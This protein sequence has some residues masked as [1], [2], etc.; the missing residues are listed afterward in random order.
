LVQ[1]K[2]NNEWVTAYFDADYNVSDTKDTSNYPVVFSFTDPDSPKFK[3]AEAEKIRQDKLEES[4]EEA[5]EFF[6][7]EFNTNRELRRR[8]I[9]EGP[10]PVYLGEHASSGVIMNSRVHS[11]NAKGLLSQVTGEI[12]LTFAVPPVIAGVSENTA[13]IGNRRVRKGSVFATINGENIEII[14][15]FIPK[16]T[17]D[18]LDAIMNHEIKGKTKEDVIKQAEKIKKYLSNFVYTKKN[19]R[20]FFLNS[21]NK[22]ELRVFDKNN[23]KNYNVYKSLSQYNEQN[24]TPLYLNISKALMND[25]VSYEVVNNVLKPTVLKQEDY[26]SYILTNSKV[27]GDYEMTDGK[28]TPVYVSPYITFEVPF[29]TEKAKAPKKKATAQA[30]PKAGKKTTTQ[31]QPVT[32]SGKEVEDARQKLKEIWNSI[33]NGPGRSAL[34][35]GWAESFGYIGEALSVGGDKYQAHGMG[36]SSFPAALK[37]LFEL[38]DKG[39]DTTRGG[40][41]LYTAPLVLSEENKAAASALG[42]AGGTAYTDGSFVLIAKKG[43]IGIK[44]INDV[45]GILVNSGL[46]DINAEILTELRKAFPNLVIESYKNTKEL[47]QQLNEKAEE[48]ASSEELVPA[49][50]QATLQKMQE[51]QKLVDRSKLTDKHYV[52]NGKT[53]RRTS[54]VIPDD[55]TG[56]STKYFASRNAG[57][58]SDKIIKAGLLGLDKTQ[59]KNQEL[60]FETSSVSKKT[61]KN[62]TKKG[63]ISEYTDNKTFDELYE[64]GQELAKEFA[65]KGETIAATDLV[66]WNEEYDT[67][68]EIDLLTVDTFGNYKIYDLKTSNAANKFRDASKL[69][70]Y[71]NQ[72]SIY[73]TL[74]SKQY[75][76]KVSNLELIPFVIGYLK[77]G[78]VV[79]V[80]NIKNVKLKYNKDVI[81]FMAVSDKEHNNAGLNDA[82]DP[83]ADKAFRTK[84]END[85][86]LGDLVEK[87]NSEEL[88][89]LKGVTG[90]AGLAVLFKAANSEYW[91]DF[92]I[93]GVNLYGNPKK[94]TG[95]HESFHVFSQMFLTKE[96]KDKLYQEVRDRVPELKDAAPIDVEEYLAE[97]FRK[98]MESGG[99]LVLDKTPVKKNFFQKIFEF[100]RAL[101][102]GRVSVDKVYEDLRMGNFFA[103]KPSVSNV[104][105]GKLASRK[106]IEGVKINALIKYS[107]AA[108]C[109]IGAI[110][111]KPLEKY[112]DRKLSSMY[113]ISD[114]LKFPAVAKIINEELYNYFEA[115]RD[116]SYGKEALELDAIL[117]NWS[118]FL[119]FSNSYSKNNY[120]SLEA[121]EKEKNEENVN[122][123]NT[124][125]DTVYDK[126]TNEESSYFMGKEATKQMIAQ[127]PACRWNGKSWEVIVSENGLMQPANTTILWNS[128]VSEMK[129]ELNH[130]KFFAKLSPTITDPETGKK[131]A[132]PEYKRIIRK[133]PELGYIME[134]LMPSESSTYK[135]HIDMRQAFFESF[136][137]PEAVVRKVTKNENNQFYNREL[138]RNNRSS[139]LQRFGVNFQ[140]F[141]DND[142]FFIKGYVVKKDRQNILGD[143]YATDMFPKLNM[144]RIKGDSNGSV[145]GKLDFLKLLG[146]DFPEVLLKEDEIRYQFD[147][148]TPILQTLAVSLK[149]RIEGGDIISDPIVALRNESFMRS[150]TEDEEGND[151]VEQI[152]IPSEKNN[153]EQLIEFIS[154]YS[155]VDSSFSALM[156]DGKTKYSIQQYNRIT[157]T[158]YGL[159]K[160]DSY[161]ELM[162]LYDEVGLDYRFLNV[163]SIANSRGSLFMELMFGKKTNDGLTKHERRR[164]LKTNQ[165]IEIILDDYTGFRSFTNIG[166]EE[167]PQIVINE[168]Y[169]TT[170]MNIRQ[171][172]VMDI[173]S[174]LTDGIINMIQPA[175][176][177]TMYSMRLSSYSETA[178]LPT[179][180]YISIDSIVDNTNPYRIPKFEE[181]YKNYLEA[182]LYKVTNPKYKKD[183]KLNKETGAMETYLDDFTYF[184]FLSP[185]LKKL[186]KEESEKLLRNSTEGIDTISFMPVIEK[187]FERIS[188]EVVAN[189]KKTKQEMVDLLGLLE[190]KNEDLSSS[191]TTKEGKIVNSDSGDL[192][193][194]FV[195]NHYIISMEEMKLFQADPKFYKEMFK[196][197]GQNISTGSIPQPSSEMINFLYKSEQDGMTLSSA[198]GKPKSVNDLYKVNF[199]VSKD[200]IE[201]DFPATKINKKGNLDFT[202]GKLNN[203]P[204]IVG[205]ALYSLGLTMKKLIGEEYDPF[206]QG[207]IQKVTNEFL[208]KDGKAAGYAKIT[209]TDGGGYCTLDFYRRILLAVNNWSDDQEA[210]YRAVVAE[211]KLLADKKVGTLSAAEKQQLQNVI[212]Y[213]KKKGAK[214]VFNILKVQTN[215]IIVDENG[216]EKPI[217][218]KFSLAPI[219]PSQVRTKKLGSLHEEML[220]KG[221]DYIPF[222]S[223]SKAFTDAQN[224]MDALTSTKPFGG[225]KEASTVI[226]LTDMKEQLL[227]SGKY[228]NDTSLGV[229]VVQ[230]AFSNILNEG[231]PIDFEGSAEEFRNAP[232][233]QLSTLGKY[234]RDY[235]T[236]FDNIRN[237]NRQKLYQELGIKVNRNG[238]LAIENA[239]LLVEKLQA[240]AE[241]R[242]ANSN[243]LDYISYNPETKDF[244][245]PLDFALNVDEIKK[246]VNGLID[247][248]LRKMRFYGSMSTQLSDYGQSEKNHSFRNPTQE[249][250]LEYGTNGLPFY[251]LKKD[252]DG[253]IITSKMG[254]KITMTGSY[255]NLYNLPEV[256]KLVNEGMEP[257]NALNKLLRTKEFREKHEEKLSIVGYRTPTQAPNSM[258]TLIIHEFLPELMGNTIIL[259]A[260]ITTKSGADYDIDKMSL[261]FKHLNKDGEVIKE[262]GLKETMAKESE[263]KLAFAELKDFK[264]ELALARRDFEYNE[265]EAKILE[266]KIAEKERNLEA[267]EKSKD[268][269]EELVENASEEE[270]EDI[271]ELIANE[272]DIIQ[273][274]RDSLE[275]YLTAIFGI[276][277]EKKELLDQINKIT[278]RIQELKNELSPLYQNQNK[279][280]G[281]LIN[282]FSSPEMFYHLT[283]PSS[284]DKIEALASKIAEKTGNKMKTYTGSEITKYISSLRKFAE[285]NGGK[286]PLGN[287]SLANKFFQNVVASDLKL[288]SVFKRYVDK[289]TKEVVEIK[290][291]NFLLSDAEE[292]KFLD[293]EGNFKLSKITGVNDEFVQQS[294]DEGISM[295]VDVE[296]NPFSVEL[297][298]NTYNTE[299]ANY[300][301]LK[302]VP[303]DRIWYFLNQPILV[304][305]YKA[306][307]ANGKIIENTLIAELANKYFGFTLGV[308][309]DDSAEGVKAMASYFRAIV[310]NSKSNLSSSEKL[311]SYLTDNPKKK[312]LSAEKAYNKQN[313][314]EAKTFLKDQ[315][316]AL[317]YYFVANTEAKEINK[318]RTNTSFDSTKVDSPIYAKEFQD[319]K[320][321]LLNSPFFANVTDFYKYSIGNKFNE[322]DTVIAV[323]GKLFPVT[324]SPLVNRIIT[325][326]KL[327][328]NKDVRTRLQKARAEKI[329]LNELIFGFI[330]NFGY[331]AVNVLTDDVGKGNTVLLKNKKGYFDIQEIKKIDSETTEYH[332]VSQAT[333]KSVVVDKS[334]VIFFV[335]PKLPYQVSKLIDTKVVV[336]EK[337]HDG[338][339]LTSVQENPKVWYER[340]KD[341]LLK[342]P[343]LSEEFPIIDR[344]LPN[345]NSKGTKVNVQLY[346]NDANETPDKDSY[347]EQFTDLIN[348]PDKEI[349]KLFKDLM[350]LA[351]YQSGYNLSKQFYFTDVLSYDVL[352]PLL[353]RTYEVVEKLME[354]KDDTTFFDQILR[355]L[356]SKVRYNRPDLYKGYTK[357]E[358]E[359]KVN[360]EYRRG[361]NYIIPNEDFA[362][363]ME[364]SKEKKKAITE[365]ILSTNIIGETK[366]GI[367]PR[368]Y[369]RERV[370]KNSQFGYV[371]TENNYSITAFP[372]R[373]GSGSAVI[374]GLAN[375]FAIVT[376]KKYDYD[377]RQNVD[378]KDTEAD[379]KEFT[380]VNAKLINNIKESGKVK[381]FFPEGFATTQAKLPTRFAKWLQ[382]ELLDNFGLVTELNEKKTGLISKKIQE[383]V[384]NSDKVYTVEEM[385]SLDPFELYPEI[386]DK[387]DKLSKVDRK[388]VDII[389]VNG[390]PELLHLGNVGRVKKGYKIFYS[391]LSVTGVPNEKD[392]SKI[393]FYKRVGKEL[394]IPGHPNIK[395]ILEKNDDTYDVYEL[396]TGLRLLS[397]NREEEK[398]KGKTLTEKKLIEELDA[399][400]TEKNAEKVISE[401]EKSPINDKST[402][403]ETFEEHLNSQSKLNEKAEENIEEE[404]LDD[405]NAKSLEENYG[406]NVIY[407]DANDDNDFINQPEKSSVFTYEKFVEEHEKKGLEPDLTE[408]QFDEYD[409]NVKKFLIESVCKKIKK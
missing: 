14:P 401:L 340:F 54:T 218:H 374:R 175:S 39:I 354:I 117:N 147:N 202:G 397:K 408:E 409:E 61:G 276:S 320:N 183:K 278:E 343:N 154:K 264:K 314:N 146:Y 342:N 275:D 299:I 160:T 63:K 403:I 333:G 12:T 197:L 296:N 88:D 62:T 230:L 402:L 245:N 80:K 119:T 235:T 194:A 134:N 258:D 250:L 391:L 158:N 181:V 393:F 11:T 281:A 141:G 6:L 263:L 259:P 13:F 322:L 237:D 182:E 277:S 162:R 155:L 364:Y 219:I 131:K 19:L 41:Q 125:R 124:T 178:P 196:R 398:G 353:R 9:E 384:P 176:K 371:Y 34:E 3:V 40:G 253:N 317:A 213:G 35:E 16:A 10:Q 31:A 32:T 52:I 132:N 114:A 148:L 286:K 144:K 106:G 112:G 366:Y 338:Q 268:L 399:F 312:L 99:K 86:L 209:V 252:K 174:F 270:G 69:A 261:L 81:N 53:F 346:R 266:E 207:N 127:V 82:E 7:T 330:Q 321:Y 27:K 50:A 20:G 186:L 83:F 152:D 64:Y 236:S 242:L 195:I 291:K 290:T 192:V 251:Y 126:A 294:F 407:D 48:G 363:F 66:V 267:L 17:L 349:S 362:E 257:L 295:A 392:K 368:K 215:G 345:T 288:T 369:S 22:L 372:N 223:S 84:T 18:R 108:D 169:E 205:D 139:I 25:P 24:K 116:K 262:L 123:E 165:P 352:L 310:V 377:T 137:K 241:S 159:S 285:L 177:R 306:L 142:S 151:T 304:E 161:E 89:F 189:F 203:V 305:L 298:A 246:L 73:S 361:R 273:E 94:G 51:N 100:L 98:Y 28:I 68:G 260:G 153:I 214:A 57:T 383:Y 231:K 373:V 388:D 274:Y 336:E 115:V 297:G 375:A 129:Y 226:Q 38:F 135:S 404:D 72:L 15:G 222:E 163:D 75:G 308:N 232:Y 367:A 357:E 378:Y 85:K 30:K 188:A 269:I 4:A 97:D 26:I 143:D 120:T 21:D 103:Y 87:I 311:F 36:K 300:L 347:I 307:D 319:E 65:A 381:I 344:L 324:S 109:A 328:P 216:V 395:L 122:D 356:L 96:Q 335:R 334:E 406:Y 396:T 171:K 77:K 233:D 121:E 318:L 49:D 228:K 234:Y 67:A 42:T 105:F 92:T 79:Q 187:N 70:R 243:V 190:I 29:E 293:D 339:I 385:K 238:E 400:I 208:R 118:D 44:N 107:K 326:K 284:V 185:K 289:E 292:N 78:E 225:S 193:D 309:F 204:K 47:V 382:K 145:Y 200:Q 168:D 90:Y 248:K 390:K 101:F 247:R 43:I 150:Y 316:K 329:I 221:I 206:S 58:V 2:V 172:M 201:N 74:F 95:Y 239:K 93:N 337:M 280:T 351:F 365:E 405:I 167:N 279:M 301:V 325:S 227:T 59:V 240:L 191:L 198:I 224:L 394:N 211:E 179:K 45:G 348:H 37:D 283:K 46:T 166:T 136:N 387:F 350:L 355:Q 313:A 271:D 282:I 386:K 199:V 130:K 244:A 254:C 23:P 113:T 376:K 170:K 323:N 71:T 389:F 157:K 370:E 255:K 220:N 102:G 56:D 358:K 265:E 149:M 229:Q 76:V 379:F 60:D 256:V 1:T 55:F 128:I 104:Y 164:F 315:L 110:M 138:T 8:A 180:H 341:V 327:A 217:L 210:L 5:E 359:D 302:H 331:P 140:K 360:W 287:Y 184:D 91:G 212:E 33:G 332:L 303:I 272:E 173:N 380:E 156:G 111:N 133:I 249:E